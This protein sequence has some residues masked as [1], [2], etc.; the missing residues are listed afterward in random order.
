METILELAVDFT[1][2]VAVAAFAAAIIGRAIASPIERL[3]EFAVRVSNGERTVMPPAGSGL[4]V[5][6][7]TQAEIRRGVAAATPDDPRAAALLNGTA[8]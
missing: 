8:P 7:L 6:R 1:I 2:L 5:R 4:E 3:T